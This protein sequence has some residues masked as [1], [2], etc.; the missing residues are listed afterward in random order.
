MP[1]QPRVVYP[2]MVVPRAGQVAGHAIAGAGLPGLPAQQPVAAQYAPA[3]AAAAARAMQIQAAQAKHRHIHHHHHHHAAV[4]AAHPP[5]AVHL[6]HLPAQ[7]HHGALADAANGEAAALQRLLD[8]NQRLQVAINHLD[9]RLNVHA[10]FGGAGAVNL[11]VHGGPAAG[12]VAQAAPPPA[13][14]PA[15]V[16][17]PRVQAR[18]PRAKVARRRR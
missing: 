18:A 7:L 1:G 4:A 15:P 17:A 8:A 10:H 13:P 9:Q 11:Q 5:A 6:H 2:A 16:P 3:A 12:P 14:V